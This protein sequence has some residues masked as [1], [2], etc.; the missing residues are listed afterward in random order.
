MRVSP[1]I[2]SLS[3]YDS[4]DYIIGVAEEWQRVFCS[5]RHGV[6]PPLDPRA[7]AEVLQ[8]LHALLEEC[9][10]TGLMLQDE[11]G[12]KLVDYAQ[13]TCGER[14]AIPYRR[15]KR[16]CWAAVWAQDELVLTEERMKV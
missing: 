6:P 11:L 3:T 1:L 14:T 12:K 15:F 4:D 13:A 7:D 9:A 2:A 5:P 10:C 8:G 16:I